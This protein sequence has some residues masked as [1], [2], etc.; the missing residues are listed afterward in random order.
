MKNLVASNNKIEKQILD[1]AFT[2]SKMAKE[3]DKM[4]KSL[5]ELENTQ[6]VSEV[7]EV[8]QDLLEELSEASFKSSIT[9]SV[10]NRFGKMI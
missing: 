9:L 10:A 3:L 2:A 5:F 6:E 1:Y 4:S 7:S 8:F